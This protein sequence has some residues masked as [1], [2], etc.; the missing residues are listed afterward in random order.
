MIP[1]VALLDVCMQAPNACLVLDMHSGQGTDAIQALLE[2]EC[3][4]DTIS[5]LEACMQGPMHLVPDIHQTQCADAFQVLL[6]EE[7]CG[8]DTTGCV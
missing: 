6:V 1:A 5:L 3:G 2:E 7:E 8:T 4:T